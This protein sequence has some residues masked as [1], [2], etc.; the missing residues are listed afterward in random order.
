MTHADGIDQ[1]F[2]VGDVVAYPGRQGSSMWLNVGLVVELT[3]QEVG[4]NSR[5]EPTLKVRKFHPDRKELGR[6]STLSRLDRFVKILPMQYSDE[7][8]ACLELVSDV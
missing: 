6:V 8:R 1:V 2:E 7:I 5:L 4:W 3:S